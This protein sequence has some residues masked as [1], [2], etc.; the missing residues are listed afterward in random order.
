MTGEE[1]TPPTD[2]PSGPV[3][4]KPWLGYGG[5]EVDKWDSLQEALKAPH[6]PNTAFT[7]YQPFIKRIFETGDRRVLFIDGE[8]VGDLVRL[9]P[10]GS[11]RANLVQGGTAVLRKMSIEEQDLTK[12]VGTFLKDLGIHL[13]GADYIDGKLTEINITAPTGFEALAALGQPNPR[14]AFC[15]LAETLARERRL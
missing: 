15:D 9:P 2:F 4:S 10:R 8:Y 12:R 6:G 11:I 5:Y 3:V 7:L 13:A 1:H 14:A